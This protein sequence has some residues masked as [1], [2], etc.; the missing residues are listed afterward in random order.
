M[1]QDVS[2]RNNMNIKFFLSVF[3]LVFVFIITVFILFINQPP[4]KWGKVFFREHNFD[5]ELVQNTISMA[6]GLMFRKFLGQDKGMLF[7]FKKEAK[8]SFWMK[9]TFI[10][11]DIIWLNKDKK[12][13][14]IIENA[15]PCKWYYCSSL[16]PTAEAKYTLEVN[17]GIVEKI[18]LMVGDNLILE[19]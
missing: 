18:G 17:G 15:Q 3:L 14:F 12:V 7:I 8:Y 5:V 13:V 1:K 2:L 4:K 9:N 10:P 6:K 19:Y 11:L 16:K